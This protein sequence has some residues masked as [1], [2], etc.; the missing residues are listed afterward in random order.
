M[1]VLQ[2][3]RELENSGQLYTWA[4]FL[5]KISPHGLMEQ[6]DSPAGCV[7]QR[8]LPTIPTLKTVTVA[9]VLSTVLCHGVVKDGTFITKNDTDALQ[10][11]FHSSWLHTDKL[12]AIGELDEIGYFFPSW[13]HRWYV[14][15][16]LHNTLPSASFPAFNIL[17]FVIDGICIYFST[18]AFDRTEN[19][20][21]FCSMFA[22]SNRSPISG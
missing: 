22:R 21:R 11:C 4:P 1:F 8:G 12:D 14:E 9:R 3:Y 16:E 5:E 13:L 6:F 10:E 15:W 2:S 18:C 19:R 17:Q 7:F 20:P